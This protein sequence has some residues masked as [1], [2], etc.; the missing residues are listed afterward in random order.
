MHADENENEEEWN[1]AEWNESENEPEDA[2]E[3]KRIVI[4]EKYYLFEGVARGDGGGE[5]GGWGTGGKG[6]GRQGSKVKV[7][8]EKAMRKETSS[9]KVGQEELK[10]EV[11]QRCIRLLAER[12]EK[13]ETTEGWCH[14][15]AHTEY[16]FRLV[17]R[18]LQEKLGS[19]RLQDRRKQWDDSRV[20]SL[21]DVVAMLANSALQCYYCSCA[22]FLWYEKVLEP[23]QWTLDRC[24]NQT[25]H[26]KE[27]V[28]IAC[29][30]CNLK[31]RRQNKE[32]FLF[33]K[34]AAMNVRK[35]EETIVSAL[36]PEDAV[37]TEMET[38]METGMENIFQEQELQVG[39][40]GSAEIC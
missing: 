26:T 5:V 16:L 24:C 33:S 20:I 14:D 2:S 21:R 12:E 4:S 28:V 29:L 15:D 36:P 9:W 31:R 11:Q 23:K 18:H 13:L 22:L 35:L 25:G 40:E 3:V 10:H 19:Y 6:R 37:E 38:E 30:E 7:R 34:T 17:R 32:A 27:N 39:G 8:K 1:E